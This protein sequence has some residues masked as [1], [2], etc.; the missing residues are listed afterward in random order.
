MLSFEQTIKHP[1]QA[2]NITQKGLNPKPFCHPSHRALCL[3]KQIKKVVLFCLFV[4]RET[5][6]NSLFI[7]FFFLLTKQ[8]LRSDIP[9]FGPCVSVCLYNFLVKFK[10]TSRLNE[11]PKLELGKEAERAGHGRRKRRGREERNK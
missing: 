4:F 8:P 7:Y 9:N 5:I 10:A 3:Y 6:R 11:I 2:E 1:H